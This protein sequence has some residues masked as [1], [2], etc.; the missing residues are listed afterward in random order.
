V[1]TGIGHPNL[2]PSVI[3]YD[4]TFAVYT[5]SHLWLS[6]GMRALDHAVEMQYHPTAT[7]VPCRSS[8]AAAV[9]DLFTYLPKAKEDPK[10]EDTITRLQLAAFNSLA[11]LGKNTKGGL[12]LS[13][14]FGYAL[15]SPYQIP[16]GVTSCL[17]LGHVVKLKTAQSKENAKRCADLL[18][19]TG[20]SRTGDDVK[21]GNAMGDA[22]LDLVERLGLKTT[23]TEQ[24]VGKDQVDIICQRAT[25]GQK[26][27][28][29]YEAVKALVMKLY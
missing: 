5:P 25:G 14:T 4:S 17:T 22:I 6:T 9:K 24:K 21:D 29:Q 20:A 12:G 11:F 15:G 26:E 7:D 1:K 2:Y 23:L 16:H 28:E 18:P 19:M 8:C 3:I 10:S 13:H 27:G